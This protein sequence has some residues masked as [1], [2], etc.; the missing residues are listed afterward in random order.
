MTGNLDCSPVGVNVCGS[1]C[2]NNMASVNSSI[3]SDELAQ[4][5]LALGA[6]DGLI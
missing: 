3:F 5:V 1:S 6:C 4:E 2:I